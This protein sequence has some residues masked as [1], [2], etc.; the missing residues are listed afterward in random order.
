MKQPAIIMRNTI[1]K[2]EFGIPRAPFA[3]RVATPLLAA[4]ALLFVGPTDAADS[5]RESLFGDDLPLVSEGETVT[6]GREGGIKG[7]LQFELARTT[8][9]P[10]HWSKM[11]TRGE[12]ASSGGLGDG[13]KWKLSARADYD[14]V[15][16][17]YDFYP[18][19]VE[20]NQRSSFALRE[21]Y[22]DISRGNWDFRLGRQHVV[23]GEMVGLFFADVVSAR[24]LREFILPEFE[25][26]R[27]PQWA[28]RAE[29]FKDD[30]HA[31]FLWIPVASYDQIGKPG[32]EFFPFQPNP[33]GG[34]VY[35]Q[36]KRPKANIDHMNYG[37]R[38]SV[39]AKGW[40]VSGFYYSSMD[41]Q[42]SF[43]RSISLV[44]PFPFIY[45]ARHDRINQFGGTVAK[46]FGEIV[47]KM[48]AVYTDGRKYATLQLSD[49]DG[50]VRQ[51]TVDWAAGLDFTLPAETRFNL[52]FFQRAYLNH[53]QGIVPD[54]NENGYSLYLNSK[55]SGV[56][57][58]QAMFIAS[59]NRPD[60]LFRPRLA[61][62]FER[63]WRLLVG[64][65]IFKGAPSGLFGQYDSKDR[66][67]SEVRYS[68]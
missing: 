13:I 62:G 52:Q 50:L 8:A 58:A 33:P 66:V 19:E 23:W 7:Y 12:L 30:F 48:E 54:R 11:R 21:N 44:P 26:M 31:E 5:E 15:Y 51:N 61:W 36:E 22:L 35:L 68:F 38:L 67:Y 37:L 65:D 39:L 16:G 2:R 4:L 53:D 9:A 42:P 46:D 20:R 60:W 10:E 25:T 59:F 49:S 14:A 3:K 41:I 40:D 28:A 43:T 1:L 29:Y 45:Q 64:A 32:A 63:N 34:S 27:I 24:D 6:K 47:F 56:L 17:I 18:P 55:L 57:E